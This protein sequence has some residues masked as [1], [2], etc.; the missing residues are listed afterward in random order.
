MNI[1]AVTDSKGGP[2]DWCRNHIDTGLP[3]YKVP[4]ENQK[5]QGAG[6]QGYWL[7]GDCAYSATRPNLDAGTFADVE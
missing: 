6:G 5:W 1:V 4:G 2:C 7:C 3:V